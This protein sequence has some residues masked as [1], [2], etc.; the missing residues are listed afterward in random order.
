MQVLQDQLHLI[1]MDRFLWI[2][3]EGHLFLK[4]SKN[5]FSTVFV[6]HRSDCRRSLMFENGGCTAIGQHYDYKVWGSIGH[7]AD[8]SPPSPL[9][10]PLDGGEN[11]DGGGDDIMNIVR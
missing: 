10:P 5:Y 6:C 1:E 8:P 2:L 4:K 9:S 7:L 11:D 3:F